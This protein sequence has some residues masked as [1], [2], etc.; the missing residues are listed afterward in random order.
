M[1]RSNMLCNEMNPIQ[2]IKSRPDLTHYAKLI[3]VLIK[4]DQHQQI[5]FLNGSSRVNSLTNLSGP[6]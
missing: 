5:M 1:T 3:L 2:S 6:D 4:L